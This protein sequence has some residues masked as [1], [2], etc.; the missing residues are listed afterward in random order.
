MPAEEE[1]GD[2]VILNERI[3]SLEGLCDPGWS[4]TEMLAGELRP[5]FASVA[6][7]EPWQLCKHNGWP[8]TWGRVSE[9]GLESDIQRAARLNAALTL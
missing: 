9:E 5:V 4:L 1:G 6:G 2:I 3:C 7:E 8:T